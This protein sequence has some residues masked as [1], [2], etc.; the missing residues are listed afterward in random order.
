MNTSTQAFDGQK[1]ASIRN[2]ETGIVFNMVLTMKPGKLSD[3]DG[4]IIAFH[5]S[6]YAGEH[7][8]EFGQFV[9][10]Y[11]ASTLRQI[12]HGRGLNLDGGVENWALCCRSIYLVKNI[13]QNWGVL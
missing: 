6:R 13:L 5:D 10:S 4:P 2:T 9:S 7:F 11:Y 12:E 1:V 3:T 8:G